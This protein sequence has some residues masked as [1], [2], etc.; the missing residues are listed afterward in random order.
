M[1]FFEI[2]F[3]ASRTN[4]GLRPLF[5]FVRSSGT[6]TASWQASSD[7][8]MPS[9]YGHSGGSANSDRLM[10]DIGAFPSQK[11]SILSSPHPWLTSTKSDMSGVFKQWEPYAASDVAYR[12]PMWSSVHGPLIVQDKPF[13]LCFH[14]QGRGCNDGQC[15][16]G[17][18]VRLCDAAQLV[19]G[20]TRLRSGRTCTS[21]DRLPFRSSSRTVLANARSSLS[22]VFMLLDDHVAVWWCAT[23]I[24]KN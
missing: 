21:A 9:S 6:G 7:P 3:V 2:L 24:F 17:A 19:P 14:I 16:H 11:W 22:C 23:S 4:Q 8:S 13:S 20:V 18:S 1:S 15:G 12:V 10:Y 5:H